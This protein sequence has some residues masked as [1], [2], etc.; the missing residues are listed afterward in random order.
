MSVCFLLF[1]ICAVDSRGIH[2]NISL[3]WFHVMGPRMAAFREKRQ[4]VIDVVQRYSECVI[5]P[6]PPYSGALIPESW[7]SSINLKIWSIDRPTTGPESPFLLHQ[8]WFG[9]LGQ[10]TSSWLL[11][12]ISC[13]SI[14]SHLIFS[15]N[16]IEIEEYCY[17][18]TFTIELNILFS[19]LLFLLY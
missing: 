7:S 9:L 17:I 8:F 6:H 3:Y 19:F 15:H 13:L 16:I 11:E 12:L 4:I 5:P 2:H 14:L 10:K 18:I 1:R